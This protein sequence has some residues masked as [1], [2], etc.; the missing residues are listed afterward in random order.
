V[1]YQKPVRTIMA[2]PCIGLACPQIRRFSNPDKFYEGIATGV[3]DG[4][5]H[6][7]NN[8]GEMNKNRFIAAAYR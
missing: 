3:P 8:V 2:Y 1:L 7:A 5:W 4:Q 6:P